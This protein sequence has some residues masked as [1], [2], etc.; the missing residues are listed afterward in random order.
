[1]LVDIILIIVLFSSVVKEEANMLIKRLIII[2]SFINYIIYNIFLT[3]KSIYFLQVKTLY[4]YK[5]IFF[6][7]INFNIKYILFLTI[8]GNVL[9]NL[10]THT[11]RQILI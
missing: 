8:F 4:F 5:L 6:R 1:M 7:K 11:I 9:S 3:K 2:N 10:Q